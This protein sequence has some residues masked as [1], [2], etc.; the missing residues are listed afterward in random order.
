MAAISLSTGPASTAKGDALV[1][2]V[3]K[4]PRGPVLVGGSDAVKALRGL[5]AAF[6]ALG[7]T[8][9]PDEVVKV[10]AP[11]GVAAD[12]VVLTGLG[13]HHRRYGAETLRRAAG[14]ATR[15]LAGRSRVALALP[16][17]TP[18][19]VEAVATGALLGAYEFTR[20]RTRSAD[21]KREGVRTLVVVSD[22]AG[23]E[24]ARAARAA[25]ARAK[26]VADATCL[27]RDLVNTPPNVLTPSEFAA[28]A[29]REAGR[30]GL[31]V[32]VLDEKALKRGGYGGIMGVG[33]GS[34][35]PPRLVR[36]GYRHP[37]ATRH[38][39]IV[40]KGITF[41]TGGISIKP[42][43]GM[44]AMKSD[45]AGAAAVLG[46]MT[47]IG[48]LKPVV[49]VTGWAPL[50]E[51]MPSGSAQRPSD[52]LTMYG[53]RT[54]E[55][56][57]TDA[58]GRLVLADALVAAAEDAPDVLVDVATLTGAQLVALG[59]R[60]AGIMANDDALRTQ[61]YE[62]SQ[63]AGES[64]WPMPLPEE[65]RKGLDSPVADI[66]N[67]D[68]ARLGGMLSGGLFLKDFV[69]DGLPWAHIDMAG[70]AF[71]SGAPYGYT[72]KG[73]TGMATRTLVLLA[74]AL[75]AGPLGH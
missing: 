74:E 25:V 52:V 27:A 11:A 72:P 14:A 2:A 51:N 18:T 21:P 4:G 36:I 44:E 70:P 12:L 39:A 30:A 56:L 16:A 33:Q 59:S 69:A 13:D 42:A 48:R 55:V 61:V 43:P 9:A 7:V 53:G 75:A 24:Q 62:A 57:N 46:A 34:A 54:V 20:F 23:G 26:A 58:E 32:T 31:A 49:N 63:L 10:P 29:T 68:N 22:L 1:V 47:A 3:A 40:G 73:G 38:L 65:L 5:A 60:T 45:M 37:R 67:A 64:M 66:A 28:V 8:G 71:N 17:A 35:T 19:E 41:D 50:A 15:S 6:A